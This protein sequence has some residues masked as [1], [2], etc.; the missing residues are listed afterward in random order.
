MKYK[1]RLIDTLIL[2]IKLRVYL[3]ILF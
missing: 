3:A 2:F 1:I